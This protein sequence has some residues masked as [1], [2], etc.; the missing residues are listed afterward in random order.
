[1]TTT[2]YHNSLRRI[3]QLIRSIWIRRKIADCDSSVRFGP[4]GQIIGGECIKIGKGTGFNRHYY[5]TAWPKC[6]QASKKA[7]IVIG[8]NCAFGAYN[9]ISCSNLIKIGDNFLSG[10]WV[11]IV[12]NSHGTTEYEALKQAPLDRTIVSKGPILIGKNVWV[13]DKA[14]ILPGVSIGDGAIV[15]ANAVVT[16]DV[17]AY[18]VAAGNPAQIIKNVNPTEDE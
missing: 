10:K 11:T 3:A 12:D 6:S 5:L 13:G 9:H 8:E 2:N 16:K 14:T 15:A 18:C 17:P 4:S 7:E 1:M